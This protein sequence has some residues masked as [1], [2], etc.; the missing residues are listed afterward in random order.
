LRYWIAAVGNPKSQRR[1]LLGAAFAGL[2]AVLLGGFVAFGIERSAHRQHEVQARQL[3][4]AVAHDLG[5]RLD[6]AL[7]AAVTLSAV[8]RQGNGK[9]DNFPRLAKELIG[10]FG[11]IAALQ[12]APDGTIREVEP[13]AGNERVIGFSPLNDPVQGPETRLVIERRQLGLAG[14]VDLRQG[15]VGIVGRNPVFIKDV[16]GNEQFWGLVQVLI[17]LPELLQ[18]TR[19]DAVE[20]AGYRYELWRLR[21]DNRVRHVFASSSDQ[22]LER[23]VDIPIPVPNGQW[24]LSV[25]PEAGWH[26]PRSLLIEAAIVSLVSLLTAVAVYL[27]LRHLQLRH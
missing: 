27:A 23:P 2:L 24:V 4:M 14:P 22:P 12:L 18:A 1:A 16:A 21:P 26:S 11:G 5:G 7:S 6:R 19:L 13:L 17:R 9:V 10:Q 3:A 8:I 20:R 15:G 25:A